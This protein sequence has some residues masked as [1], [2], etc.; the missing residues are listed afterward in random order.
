MKQKI[1][2]L[3]AIFTLEIIVPKK[4]KKGN[5]LKVFNYLYIHRHLC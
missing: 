4:E 1:V 2:T 3:M 5:I